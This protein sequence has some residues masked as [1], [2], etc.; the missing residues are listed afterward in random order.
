MTDHQ[1]RTALALSALERRALRIDGIISYGG[2]LAAARFAGIRWREAAVL[3][4]LMNTRGLMELIVLNIGL[5][6]KIISPTL[7]TMLVIM[8]IVTTFLTTPV[9]DVLTARGRRLGRVPA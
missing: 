7:F 5:D 6:L 4:T 1:G 3:A 2:S 9:V 8:A